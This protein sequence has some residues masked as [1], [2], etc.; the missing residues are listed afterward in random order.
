MNEDLGAFPVNELEQMLAKEK[1]RA[2][3][4]AEII[5]AL[6]IAVQQGERTAEIQEE[7]VVR[8]LN[9]KV[10]DIRSGNWEIVAGIQSE[11]EYTKSNLVE[12]LSLCLRSKQEVQDR[13]TRQDVN[14]LSILRKEIEELEKEAKVVANDDGTGIVDSVR[15]IIGIA[16][17]VGDSLEQEL[18]ALQEDIQTISARNANLLKRVSAAQLQVMTKPPGHATSTEIGALMESPES[19]MRRCSAN[20]LGVAF[21]ESR[22]RG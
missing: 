11:E 17:R 10:K 13:L 8:F 21:S 20:A 14:S 7:R 16:D 4:L 1:Q 19:K 9:Q 3:D 18:S 22:F 2:S 6:E 5:G 12:K 15:Q